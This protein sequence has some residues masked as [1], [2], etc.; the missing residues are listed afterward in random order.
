M[1]H[2]RSKVVAAN[3]PQVDVVTHFALLLALELGRKIKR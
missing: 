3:V 1:E 2:C